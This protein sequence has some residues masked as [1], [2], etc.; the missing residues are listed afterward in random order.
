MRIGAEESSLILDIS[1]HLC[2]MK[3]VGI[4]SVIV[5]KSIVALNLL[6][7]GILNLLPEGVYYE[8]HCLLQCSF[9]C[10]CLKACVYHSIGCIS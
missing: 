2:T 6:V 4:S 3:R 10:I 8:L 7:S 1:T 9:S 5:G